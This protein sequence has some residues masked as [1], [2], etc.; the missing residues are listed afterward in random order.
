MRRSL[1]LL[2]QAHYTAFSLLNK[3]KS[4]WQIL[5]DRQSRGAA[6]HPSILALLLTI[7]PLL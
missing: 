3:R 2:I 4:P 6:G 1:P 5:P 7:S